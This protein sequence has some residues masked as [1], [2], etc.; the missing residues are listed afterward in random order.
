MGITLDD[1]IAEWWG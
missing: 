1:S